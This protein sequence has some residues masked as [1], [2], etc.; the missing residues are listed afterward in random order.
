MSAAQKISEYK[1]Y[2]IY[3][4]SK[5]TAI[6]ALLGHLLFLTITEIITHAYVA[7]Y[8]LGWSS[9]FHIYIMCLLPIPFFYKSIGKSWKR[10]VIL[11][12]LIFYVLLNLLS[13]T[14]VENY[15]ITGRFFQYVELFNFLLAFVVFLILSS[16]YSQAAMYLENQLRVKNHELEMTSRLD[17]LTGLSNRRDIMDKIQYEKEK[18]LRNKNNC[19]FILSDIDDFKK[20]NDTYGHDYGD[21]TLKQIADILK[22]GLRMQDNICR[23]GGEEFLLI[24]PDTGIEG[25]KIVAE[26]I[27]KNISNFDFQ[28]DSVHFNITMTF[29]VSSFDHTKDIDDCIKQADELL[30]VGKKSGKNKVIIQ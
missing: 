11:I 7:T 21:Y 28:F 13:R 16:T 17:P 10:L 24:L 22:V 19:T 26:K 25:G 2:P 23:W 15:L 20:I 8:F 12:L 1:S 6:L 29:G 4:I 14:W 9:G 3:L 5:Y 18:I 27:R 30:Y